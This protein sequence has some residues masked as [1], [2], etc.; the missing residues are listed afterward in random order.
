[1]D[2]LWYLKFVQRVGDELLELIITIAWCMCMC[3]CMCMWYNRNEVRHGSIILQ[4]ARALLDKFQTANL[5]Y[6]YMHN[7][8]GGKI[9]VSRGQN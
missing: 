2:L 6:I 1:M 9:L 4:K 3:M 8:G 7:S 5:K